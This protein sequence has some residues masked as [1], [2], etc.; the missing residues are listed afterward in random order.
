MASSSSTV[1]WFPAA[2]GAGIL[3]GGPP[4]WPVPYGDVAILAASL[5]VWW[6]VAVA[7]GVPVAVLLRVVVEGIQDPTTHNL[8]P[9]ESALALAI[10]VLP[11]LGG[12]YIG[13]RLQRAGAWGRTIR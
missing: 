11:A 2:L 7:L 12:A 8:W 9:L 4:L 5:P 1:P 10:V 13:D 6:V 3:A